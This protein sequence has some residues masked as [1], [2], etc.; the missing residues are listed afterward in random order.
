MQRIRVDLPDPEGPQMTI[1]S[2]LPTVRSIFLR[3]WKAPIPL[4]DAGQMHGRVPVRA[5]CAVRSLGAPPV[6]SYA[7]SE[8]AVYS[9]LSATR[10]IR[11]HLAVIFA[12]LAGSPNWRT[13]WPAGARRA[14]QVCQPPGY[15]RD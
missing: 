9:L 11:Q 3:T 7:M 10:L 5:L 8:Y 14:G 4:V 1:F 15:C 13:S 2:P 6:C 12:A